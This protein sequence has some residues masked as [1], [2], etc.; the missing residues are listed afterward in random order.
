M[1]ASGVG[2]LVGGIYL[3]RH[4]S[5]LELGKVLAFGTALIPLLSL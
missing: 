5:V 2:T 3:S 4:K 1:T